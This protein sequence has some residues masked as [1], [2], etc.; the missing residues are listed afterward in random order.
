MTLGDEIEACV[1]DAYGTLFDVR[2]AVGRLRD[3]V[4]KRAGEL[5]GIWRAKQ[6]E[7]TWLRSLMGTHA[8]FW[9]ITQDALD[10]AMES[11]RIV[12]VSLREA[13]VN[14]YLDLDCYPEVPAALTAIKKRG[15]RTAIL[16]NGSPE[17]LSAAVEAAG[18]ADSLD[19]WYSV[20]E[21][22][23]F[24]PHPRVYQLACDQLRLD[25]HQISFQSSNAW[26]VA[27]AAHFGLKTVWVNRFGQEPERIPGKPDAEIENLEELLALLA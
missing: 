1:F 21:V 19:G 13:L 2:S 26:D 8:D 9:Q 10:Y 16:S 14:A 20:E 17:M 15:L 7:Y 22:G 11:C 6:L 23:I 3:R 5:S 27:G 12:D 4:G 24:K 18:L 25:R